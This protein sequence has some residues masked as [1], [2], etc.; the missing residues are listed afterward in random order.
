M[1]FSLNKRKLAKEQE[2]LNR[3]EIVMRSH[4]LKKSYRIVNAN[5]HSD[6]L[7]K[8]AANAIDNLNKDT[9]ERIADGRIKE[10]QL[11][12]KDWE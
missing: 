3:A 10:E 11:E 7:I 8:Q 4:L 9:R 6:E 1:A 12:L 5:F 2:D